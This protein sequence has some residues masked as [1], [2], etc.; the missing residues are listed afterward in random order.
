MF[1]GIVK[2]TARL[3]ALERKAG[4]STL[5]LDFPPGF[6]AELEAGASVAVD[7][8]CLT[9]TRHAS[10]WAEFDVMQES[11]VRTTL[12]DIAVGDLFNVERAAHDG[13][14]IGG[15][16]LSGHVD[17]T[18]T[19]VGIETPENNK[20][21]RFEVAPEW[22]HYIFAKGYIAVNGCSLTVSDA[23][24]ASRR[25]SVWFIPETLR[26]TT[27]DAKTIGSRVN[28]EIERATQVTVDTIRNYLDERLGP[29][30]PRLEALLGT[31]LVEQT[32]AS[33]PGATQTK[34]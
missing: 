2:G 12:A 15:H 1:T 22:M 33:L 13:A 18:A 8:V 23:D 3:S 16:P 27:F 17:C 30:L 34:P 14:E 11:L 25:F 28:I 29:L 32:T 7:G 9:V 31:S 24:R 4:L 10:G 21:M 19:V 26:M 6:D 5:T 20:V